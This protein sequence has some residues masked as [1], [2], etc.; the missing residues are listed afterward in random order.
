MKFKGEQS[1]LLTQ[2][3]IIHN[4]EPIIFIVPVPYI[5][6]EGSYPGHGN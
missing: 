4:L 3:R 1:E 2:V 5:A 6:K